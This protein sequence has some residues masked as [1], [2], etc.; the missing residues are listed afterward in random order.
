MNYLGGHAGVSASQG[1]F[2]KAVECSHPFYGRKINRIEN[3]SLGWKIHLNTPD[4]AFV[5]TD[6]CTQ[7]CDTEEHCLDSA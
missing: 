4:W 1:P 6:I 5:E 7:N 3:R 2:P